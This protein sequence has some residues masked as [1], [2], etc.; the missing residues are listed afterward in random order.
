MDTRPYLEAMA[1]L[2]DID[3][4]GVYHV[5]SRGNFRQEVF[6]DNVCKEGHFWEVARYIPIN[7]VRARLSRLPEDWRWSGHRAIVGLEHPYR[8]HQPAEL[9]RYFDNRP[10]VAVAKYRALVHEGLVRGG[11]VTW[12]DQG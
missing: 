11:H 12:S 3:P 10:E 1:P 7:P 6:L 9:L 8:F 2:R 5:M 4:E